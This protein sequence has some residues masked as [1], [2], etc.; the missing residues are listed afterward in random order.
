MKKILYIINDLDFF[1]SHRLPLAIAAK[2]NNFDVYISSSP[3]IK[4]AL[5]RRKY[6]INFIPIPISRS[7]KKI[8]SELLLFISIFKVIF[9]LKPSILQ[10]S[11]IKPLLYGGIISR[12]LKI[13]LTVFSI[14][15]LGHVFHGK[16][17][18]LKKIILFFFKF[19]LKKKNSAIF[20][21][22]KS[23]FNYL[24]RFNV[25]KKKYVT[26][27]K[28]SGVNLK[29]FI[30][31]KKN[32]KKIIITM[33]S[34]MSKEKGVLEFV[35]ASK[36]FYKL[37]KNISFLLVGKFDGDGPSF[38]PLETLQK[39]ND[40]KVYPNLSW[41]GHKE[42]VTKIMQQST[43]IVLPSYHEGVP[44]V[45]LEAAACGKPI[46]A[47]NIAGCRVVVENNKNGIL[48]KMKSPIA[49]INAIKNI[50]SKSSKIDNMGKF[51][52]LKASKEF[53][54]KNVLKKYLKIYNS[55]I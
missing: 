52:R 18:F 10:L 5:L 11:T 34:R 8:L 15:G 1:I 2:K 31:L 6:G 14:G 48:I 13:N 53:D 17:F 40:K 37:R 51:S 44:K 21:Q 30:P 55:A 41:L 28:G 20:L 33:I 12:I 7:K 24:N 32:N 38:I 29:K 25:I 42:N 43:I 16:G 22:N 9:S 19:S 36:K 46:I 54:I 45:L 3:N 47:T 27:T 49:I 26:F 23:D 4:S 35:E 39:F 50:L